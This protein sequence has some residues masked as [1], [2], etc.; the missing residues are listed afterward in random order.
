MADENQKKDSSA[1]GKVTSAGSNANKLRKT[2]RA[3]KKVRFLIEAFAT[4]E[5]WVPIVIVGLTIGVLFIVLF[6]GVAG[7]NG[8][9]PPSPSPS[10]TNSPV[11]LCSD[12]GGICEIG[13][14]AAPDVQGTG[15]CS[16]N[17]RCCLTSGSF[18]CPSGKYAVCL[19]QSFNVVVTGTTN[20]T[21]LSKISF[22]FAYASKSSG[23]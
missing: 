17:R 4:S 18:T 15:F 23:Y 3:A 21:L 19:K 5:V 7:V 12:Q 22:A 2:Y 6:G 1:V 13:A 16:A 10:P 14:C 9:N 11:A 20:S 8:G